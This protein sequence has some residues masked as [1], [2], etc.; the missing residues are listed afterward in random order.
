MNEMKIRELNLLAK[1]C[2]QNDISLKL[3]RELLRSAK[4]LSYENVSQNARIKEYQ[5]LIE[6]HAKNNQ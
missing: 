5:D 1:I 6:F 3:A 4:S 2:D